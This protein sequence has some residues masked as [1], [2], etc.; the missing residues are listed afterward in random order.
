MDQKDN[1]EILRTEPIKQTG[2]EKSV[3]GL[4]DSGGSG[5]FNDRF[6]KFRC[7]QH[8]LVEEPVPVFVADGVPLSLDKIQSNLAIIVVVHFVI[9]RKGDAQNGQ[10]EQKSDHKQAYNPRIVIPQAIGRKD[11]RT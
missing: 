8:G 1:Q 9:A 2:E 7:L 4:F 5:S 6:L 11:L 10:V 3:C